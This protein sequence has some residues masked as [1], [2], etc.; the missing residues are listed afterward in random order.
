MWAI[1]AMLICVAVL[2][3]TYMAISA[4]KH[5]RAERERLRKEYEDAKAK[6]Q[7]AVDDHPGDVLL[8]TTLSDNVKRLRKVLEW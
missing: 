7:K 8:H 2:L 6:L 4:Q 5:E 3:W 1:V